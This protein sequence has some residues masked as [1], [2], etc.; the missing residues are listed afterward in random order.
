MDV[1]NNEKFNIHK[2][3]RFEYRRSKHRTLERITLC[4]IRTDNKTTLEQIT[5]KN[6][7]LEHNRTLER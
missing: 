2:N 6:I 7:A 5:L 1:T 4:N 3:I